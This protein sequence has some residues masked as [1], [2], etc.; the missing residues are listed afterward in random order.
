MT[1]PQA[2][3]SAIVPVFNGERYLEE[4][5]RSAVDQSLPPFEVIVVDD[6]STDG[7]AEIAESFGGPVRCIR[8]A[9]KGVAGARNQ[10]LSAA[11]GEFVGFIDHDDLWPQ[12]KLE[13]QVAALR[14]RPDLGIV[15]GRIRVFGGAIPGRD[16]SATGDR[17]SAEAIQLGSRLIRRSVFEEIGPLDESVGTADDLEWLTRARDLGVRI[18][19]Q[20]IVTLLYRWH[21]ENISHDIDGLGSAAVDALKISMDRRRGRSGS[22]RD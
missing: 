11:T 13:S 19:S 22:E 16:W 20:D 3:V 1:A 6:G 18:E 15:S 17:D 5:L 8:Q 9:N 4:C 14:A 10:G 12:G 2:L 21:E 7:S